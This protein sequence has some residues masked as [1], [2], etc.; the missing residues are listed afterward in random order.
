MYKSILKVPEC[1][2]ILRK[3]GVNMSEPAFRQAIR[4]NQVKNTFSTSK[5]EGINIPLAS[6]MDF[7]IPRLPGN[8]AAFELGKFYY[9]QMI[10]SE[11]LPAGGF[12]ELRS[13]IANFLF[14]NEFIY[15]SQLGDGQSYK[16]FQLYI[17]Y[18]TFTIHLLDD[19]DVGGISSINAIS[20]M[21][22][23]DIWQKL[24]IDVNDE[25]LEK[26]CV[27]IYYRTS[28]SYS[29]LVGFYLSELTSFGKPREP[30]YSRFEQLLTN[31][32]NEFI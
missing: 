31:K 17:D 7:M 24:G 6:F 22:V 23:V 10:F 28:S 19:G 2:D 30:L 14:R 4:K 20:K 16:S 13:H 26:T 11:P 32:E 3:Y 1:L 5:K 15:L 18:D 9:E 27:N 12:G 8:H 29:S 21:M 25:L